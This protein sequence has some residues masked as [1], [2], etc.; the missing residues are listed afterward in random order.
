[1][2]SKQKRFLFSFLVLF[3]GALTAIYF[4]RASS[5]IA[6]SPSRQAI[7]F[8]TYKDLLD[9]APR[10]E[11]GIDPLKENVTENLIGEYGKE[12]FRLNEDKAGKGRE[13]LA[14][15]TMPDDAFLEGIINKSVEI[16][17]RL[18]LFTLEDVHT[19]STSS[20]ES[21]Q[22]WADSYQDISTKY[23]GKLNTHFLTAVSQFVS[24]SNTSSLQDH[25]AAYRAEVEELLALQVPR[26][27][28]GLHL[29][30]L[31]VWQRRLMIGATL[32]LGKDDSLKIPLA[33]NSLSDLVQE[34]AKLQASLEEMTR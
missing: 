2:F 23:V 3:F 26:S 12:F 8:S 14:S 22:R 33:L 4:L 16:P 10:A 31:N 25:L 1:M 13:A 21:A 9:T 32:E 34:E 24:D 19:I 5:R 6:F 7:S 30:L 15:L 28:A 18:S 29:Q 20:P 17:L 27:L 11:P